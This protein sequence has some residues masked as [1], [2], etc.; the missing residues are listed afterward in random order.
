[1]CYPL[2][3]IFVCDAVRVCSFIVAT[4]HKLYVY[5]LVHDFGIS[6]ANALE[7]PESCTKP[8]TIIGSWILIQDWSDYCKLTSLGFENLQDQLRCEITW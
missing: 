7:I 5:G 4:K 3:V 2:E 1:M 8:L 6:I